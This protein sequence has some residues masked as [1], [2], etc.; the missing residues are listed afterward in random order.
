[1]LPTR[2]G[3]QT[4]ITMGAKGTPAHI[5]QWRATWERDLAGKLG[6]KVQLQHSAKGRGKLV[7]SY[8]NADELEGIL[9]HIKLVA[10]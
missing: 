5:L 10:E 6:A 2:A 8:N 1:M 4:A 3:G 9:D 7:I